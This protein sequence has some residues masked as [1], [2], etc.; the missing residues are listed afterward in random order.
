MDANPALMETAE[1]VIMIS[2]DSSVIKGKGLL[3]TENWQATDMYVLTVVSGLG[4][5]PCLCLRLGPAYSGMI[6]GPVCRSCF[7]LFRRK[8]KK[9]QPLP[10]SGI[11]FYFL[12]NMIKYILCYG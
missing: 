8:T 6:A 5:R 3:M 4:L 2:N 12:C 11:P 9:M 7:H 10:Q 1:A